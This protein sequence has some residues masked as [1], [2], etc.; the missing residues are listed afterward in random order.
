MAAAKRRLFHA[1]RFSRKLALLSGGFLLVLGASGTAALMF[2][3]ASLLPGEEA[4]TGGHCKTLYQSEFR[5]GEEKRLIA[6]IATDDREP[7]SRVRTGM[8]IARHLAETLHPDLVIVQVADDHGPTLR[9]D[10]RGEA[11]GAEIVHA[12]NPGKTMATSKPWEARYVDAQPTETGFYFGTRIDMR[13]ADLETVNHEIELVEG[14]DG[15]KVDEAPQ[16]ASAGGH[17]EPAASGHGEPAGGHE[18]P[19]AGH[20]APSH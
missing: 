18:A 13:L 10:L 20:A 5:R 4:A 16:T 1:F 19:A 11:I 9:A 12:P 7:R 8:R 3:P 15:D 2:A 14:C 6:V 17:G